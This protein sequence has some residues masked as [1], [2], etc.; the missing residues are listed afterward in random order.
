M[1]CPFPKL[2]EPIQ[3]GS[4]EIKNRVIM[5]GMSAHMAPDEGFVTDREVAF[6]ERR[7]AGD[8]GFV[9]VGA[10]FVHA[11]G[12]FGAQLGIHRDEMIP[13]LTRL[14]GVIRKHGALASIQLHHAGRQTSTGVTG[15]EHLF[16]PSAIPCPVKQEMPRAM[17][18]EDI[19]TA[20]EWYARGAERAMEAGFDGIEVH[21]AHGYLPAQFLSPRANQRTDAYGGSLENR[22]RFFTRA[23]RRVREV[24]GPSIPLTVKISGN[25]YVEQG[26]TLEETPRIARILE[27]AGVDLVAI[28]AGVAPYYFTVPNMTLPRGCYVEM[29]RAVKAVCT[30]PISAVGRIPTPALAE[31]ILERGDADMISLG[32]ALIADPDFLLKARRG[33][34]DDICTCIGCN[35]GCHDPGR[36]E[37]ATACLLNAEAGY[38]RELSIDPPAEIKRVLV[39]GGGPGG[40]EA[41]RVAGLRGHPV[42]ICER[43][44][45]W[46]GRLYLGTLPPDKAEYAVGIQY[47]VDQCT[48]HGVDMRLDTPVTTEMVAEIAPDVVVFATGADPV[49]PPIEGLSACPRGCWTERE[50]GGCVSAGPARGR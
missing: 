39:V 8:I 17:T 25:E 37:R 30:I 49:A 13:G 21:G 43:E 33:E 9:V 19:D 45:Y 18:I 24:V 35:K 6:Y 12:T 14:A 16:A 47:L 28:S 31:E 36:S 23:V 4:R 41:A 42:V 29:A 20:I 2:L 10:A 27:E 40:L 48:K 38:E 11:S 5:T 15:C 3:I 50:L 32:R 1:R 7:A 26:L 22:T 46:G 44:G 34:Q